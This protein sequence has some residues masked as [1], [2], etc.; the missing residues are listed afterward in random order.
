MCESKT[1]RG[2]LRLRGAWA[3]ALLLALLAPVVADAGQFG[4][5]DSY[6]YPLLGKFERT[7][8]GPG[9]TV[10]ESGENYGIGIFFRTPLGSRVLGSPNVLEAT[11][12]DR[13]FILNARAELDYVR[14]DVAANADG[15]ASLGTI[16]KGISVPSATGEAKYR[17]FRGE[18]DVG[19]RMSFAYGT[20]LEP[21]LGLGYLYRLK[22]TDGGPG[23]RGFTEYAHLLHA[24][25]G[26]RAEIDV[27][28]E[29]S[30][31][32]EAGIRYGLISRV[33]ENLAPTVS[34]R[35]D[36]GMSDFE[37]IGFR[38]AQYRIFLFHERLALE[39]EADG[40]GLVRPQSKERTV[41]IRVGFG[42]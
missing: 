2:I 25:P 35:P 10:E 42:Y 12:G 30:V 6:F 1:R 14:A 26:V 27:G 19:Y 20:T 3:S 37:T 36:T 34:Y 39:E 29:M 4:D 24:R 41:G 28:P 15:A 33:K 21:F 8:S 13:R 11:E 38:Y 5:E 40:S 23:F 32:A 18:G 9:V 7:D 31:F 16:Y 17:F 22:D